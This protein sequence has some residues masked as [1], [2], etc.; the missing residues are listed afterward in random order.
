MDQKE[1]QAHYDRQMRI[2][3]EIPGEIKEAFPNLVRFVRPAPGMNYVLF[4]QLEETEMDAVI[5]EQ[6]AFFSQMAQPFNWKIF[7]H[8]NAAFLEERL[9]AYGYERVDDDYDVIMVL[10]LEDVPERLL[11]PVAKDVR[12]LIQPEQIWD[13]VN[14]LAEAYGEDFSWLHQ[15][16]GPII[17]MPGY[18]NLFA[19]YEDGK[20]VACGW[21]YCYPKIEFAALFGETI[22][23]EYRGNGWFSSI[24]ASEV[25]RAKAL[26]RR[27]VTTGVE[28]ECQGMLEKFGFKRIS[29]AYYLYWKGVTSGVP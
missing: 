16:M 27:Y 21:A 23:K 28:P 26:G 6:I 15:R 24:L 10:D 17:E 22:L 18:L 2:E 5:H 7:E 11:L 4:S 20:P 1:M 9:Q 8:D 12:Q 19:G 25:Q 3:L 29:S 13:V 14:V